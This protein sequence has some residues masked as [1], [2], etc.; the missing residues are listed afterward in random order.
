MKRIAALNDISG[1]GRCSLS[2]ALP[3]ISACGVECCPLPTAVLT[4][5]TAFE[6][7]RCLDLTDKMK[8]FC[9]D[10]AGERFDG[11][12]TG[13]FSHPSQA[14]I[15]AEFIRSH[16]DAGTV[17]VDPVLGDGGRPYSVFSK[18]LFSAVTE[19]LQYATAI[20]PNL[21]ELS[22]LAGADYNTLLSADSVELDG[23]CRALMSDRLKTVFVTGIVRNGRM[24]NHI[25]SEDGWRELETDVYPGSFSGTG[26]LFASV[27]AAES[28]K[29]SNPVAAAEKAVSFVGAS[30]K[31][32]L[33]EKL[34]PRYGTAFQL[35]LS[36]LSD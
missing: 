9:E 33:E 28:V 23:I 20:T 15:A 19:L 1:F 29:G 34:D 7:S 22:L 26:D 27:C 3:V 14:L 12:Y 31:K 32:S 2:A 10:W 6:S 25:S 8:A 35:C 16:D 13:F 21:T 18:D 11:I 24:I 30:V 4:R 36:L 17:L 5:Q